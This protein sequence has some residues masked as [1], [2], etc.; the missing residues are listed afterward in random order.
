MYSDNIG[1]PFTRKVSQFAERVLPNANRRY[2]S[3]RSDDCR[4]SMLT[5]YTRYF[6][7]R[8]KKQVRNEVKWVE[9]I[10]HYLSACTPKRLL[11]VSLSLDKLSPQRRGPGALSGLRLRT[12]WK[13]FTKSMISDNIGVSITTITT[14]TRHMSIWN[15]PY[16][17]AL[18]IAKRPGETVHRWKRKERDTRKNLGMCVDNIY[19]TTT[20]RSSESFV[21][22][23]I[24]TL[25]LR[26][27]VFFFFPKIYN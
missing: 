5:F 1:K 20:P 4:D 27:G 24:P 22:V 8:F 9:I 15:C 14:L 25:C 3:C 13:D 7:V 12:L 26:Q 10:S 16:G 11:T 23:K 17:P 19:S 18:E 2:N 6:K 21:D